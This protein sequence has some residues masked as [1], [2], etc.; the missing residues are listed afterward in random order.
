MPDTIREQ[1]IRL[2][3][4]K[5]K[6]CDIYGDCTED[7]FVNRVF[8]ERVERMGFDSDTFYFTFFGLRFPAIQSLVD[9]CIKNNLEMDIGGSKG[10]Q[11]AYL[12]I[13]IKNGV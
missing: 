7:E 1:L 13:R 5:E 12:N 4:E 9:F 2:I 8:K 6:L 3:Y 10:Y 11:E